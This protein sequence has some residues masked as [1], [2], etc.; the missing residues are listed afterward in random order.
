M[1]S[2]SGTDSKPVSMP[3]NRSRCME[4]VCFDITSHFQHR[5]KWPSAWL[6]DHETNLR[7]ASQGANHVSAAKK[8]QTPRNDLFESFYVF[9]VRKSNQ[10]HAA[11]SINA[12]AIR[13]DCASAQITLPL[14][15]SSASDD[16]ARTMMTHCSDCRNRPAVLCVCLYGRGPFLFRFLC[17]SLDFPM[18]QRQ[19]LT[20]SVTYGP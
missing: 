6:R 9:A 10:Q 13:N 14:P 5:S 8:P 15:G 1:W 17:R 16:Y 19:L 11:H 3:A 12:C 7:T 2:V 4:G 18:G 20:D